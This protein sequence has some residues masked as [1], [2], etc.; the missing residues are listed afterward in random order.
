M[1]TIYLVSCVSV[2]CPAPMAAKDLYMSSWFKKARLYVKKTGC[3]WFILSAEHGLI[4]PEQVIAPYEKTLNTMPVAARRDWAK[5]V[6][7]QLQEA[8]PDMDRAVF[9]AGHRYREF[10]VPCFLDRG[11]AVEVPM[12]GLG[13][14]EQL[15]WLGSH[16]G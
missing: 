15:S 12:Q 3:D 10:L 4:G 11:I 6:S 2:K 14:G 5:R 16:D 9:L 1:S 13:I 7:A 8:M